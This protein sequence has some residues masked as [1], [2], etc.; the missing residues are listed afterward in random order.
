MHSSSFLAE[1]EGGFALQSLFRVPAVRLGVRQLCDFVCPGQGRKS[2]APNYFRCVYVGIALGSG[3][4]GGRSVLEGCQLCLCCSPSLLC[5]QLV[6]VRLFWNRLSLGADQSASVMSRVPGVQFCQRVYSSRLPIL[7]AGAIRISYRYYCCRATGASF[8]MVVK[9][10]TRR[11]PWVVVFFRTG[12][13]GRSAGD[14]GWGCARWFFPTPFSAGWRAPVS[15]RSPSSGTRGSSSGTVLPG[16]CSDMR[17]AGWW[18]F[19]A[20]R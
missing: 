20:M 8:A 15:A 19:A 3:L 9:S 16:V 6:L 5:I 4:K 11:Q 13:R 17:R 14:C 1:P 18:V 10:D 2:Q 7:S 12:R